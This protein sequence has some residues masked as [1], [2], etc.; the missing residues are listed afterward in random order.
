MNKDF[1][2]NIPADVLLKTKSLELDIKSKDCNDR[3]NKLLKKT[4]LLGG[5]RLR[6]MLTYLFGQLFGHSLKDLEVYARAIECVHAASL[7]HDDVVDGA[8]TRRGSP[9]INTLSS[10]KY[11]VLAGDYLLADVI[12][13][14]Y[15]GF[16]CP[17]PN[18]FIE[19]FSIK[20]DKSSLLLSFRSIFQ[21]FK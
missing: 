13:K 11:A 10:N 16:D 4:V 12:V 3:V 21:T 18:F 19:I 7:S 1:L 8:E 14:K 9:S 2:T 20:V 15:V 6:P 5:K 17:N